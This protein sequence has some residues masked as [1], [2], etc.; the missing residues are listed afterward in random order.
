[1]ILKGAAVNHIQVT[2][3][4]WSEMDVYMQ[5]ARAKPSRVG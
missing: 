1:M 2:V 3:I 5:P 4:V